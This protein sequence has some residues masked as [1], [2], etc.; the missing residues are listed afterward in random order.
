M[1]ESS[2]GGMC[3]SSSDDTHNKRLE[4][5]RNQRM[6]ERVRGLDLHAE[7]LNFNF[8]TDEDKEDR[9]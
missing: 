1:A 9:L 6:A 2:T 8:S 5:L 3:D 7:N 4:E